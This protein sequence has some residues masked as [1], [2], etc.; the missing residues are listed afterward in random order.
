MVSEYIG[1][2]ALAELAAM[3]DRHRAEAREEGRQPEENPELDALLGMLAKQAESMTRAY[4]QALGYH[5]HK[6]QWRKK[7]NGNRDN[8]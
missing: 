2:G 3:Q 7:R 1:A 8:D 4:L 5:Q 6:G